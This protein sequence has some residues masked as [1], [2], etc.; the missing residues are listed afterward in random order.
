[1]YETPLLKLNYRNKTIPIYPIFK[2]A[3]KLHGPGGRKHEFKITINQ[4]A[5][6]KSKYIGLK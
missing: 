3:E 5:Y 1:M 6:L 2:L 4:I